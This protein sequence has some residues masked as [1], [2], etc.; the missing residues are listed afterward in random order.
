MKTKKELIEENKRLAKNYC[1][2]FEFNDKLKL[3]VIELKQERDILKK[4]TDV[5]TLVDPPLPKKIYCKN[6]RFLDNPSL[7]SVYGMC[8][9]TKKLSE[10]DSAYCVSPV[11]VENYRIQNGNND[12]EY[13][14]KLWWK[15]WVKG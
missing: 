11:T 14:K 5:L 7:C 15:F 9:C 8:Q 13:Y 2:L 3:E 1:D 6:C 12:C 10:R 4:I